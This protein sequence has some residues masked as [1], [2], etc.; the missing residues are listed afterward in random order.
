[1]LQ[2]LVILTFIYLS[3]L[4]PPSSVL[5]QNADSDNISDCFGAVDLPAKGAFKIAFTNSAGIFDDV[6]NYKS[7]LNYSESN[8]IWMRFKAPYDG[9][10]TLFVSN[11]KFEIEALLFNGGETYCK[12]ILNG[13]AKPLQYIQPNALL[14]DIDT[15]HLKK[16]EYVYIYFNST[17]KQVNQLLVNTDFSPK[18]IEESIDELKTEVDRRTDPTQSYLRI[19]IRDKENNL[20]VDARIIISES[21]S[22]DAMYQGTDILLPNDRNLKF[23]IKIDA[24]GYFF[25]DQEIKTSGNQTEEVII[26]LEPLGTGKQVELQGIHFLP[27][28]SEFAVD[29]EMRLKR[30]RDFLAL[31]SDLDIEIQGH[32][33]RL[34]N[35]NFFSKRLSKKRAKKVMK[36]LI[37]SGISKSRLTAV[38]YGNLHMIHPEP[39]SKSEEQANRR[40]EIKIL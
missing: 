36:Y 8:S 1:M 10:F 13:D 31:N 25:S 11:E 23:N 21:K 32:V 7:T 37:R 12:D 22:Y 17:Q 19:A 29:A 39:T 18:N 5:A 35:N 16:G 38:G 33:Y 28:S 26:H 40:V 14:S 6:Y 4:T 15:V 30:V 20:P 3:N 9:A 24:I 2:K 27:Q 34:G